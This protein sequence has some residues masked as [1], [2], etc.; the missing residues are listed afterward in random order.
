MEFS[1]FE[2]LARRWHFIVFPLAYAGICVIC[3]ELVYREKLSSNFM[4][5]VNAHAVLAIAGFAVGVF[6][7]SQFPQRPDF[8]KI[9]TML[10]GGSWSP[11]WLQWLPF[12]PR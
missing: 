9:F 6:I 5:A 10:I 12:Y 11:W 7:G 4:G 2:Y 8:G 1:V 3:R